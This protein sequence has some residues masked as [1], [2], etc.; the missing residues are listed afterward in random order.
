MTASASLSAQEKEIEDLT[1]DQR[2]I[3]V[4]QLTAKVTEQNLKDFFG[5]LG[6]VRNVIMIRDKATGRHKGFAYIEMGDLET[7]PNCLLFNNVV[8]D[9]QKFAILV[10]ASEA[11]KNFLAKKESASAAARATALPGDAMAM[12]N[13]LYVGNLHVNVVE[14]D[15][16]RLL[17]EIGP[18]ESVNIQ[19]DELGQSKGYAFVRM[20]RPQD[21]QTAMTRLAGVELAGRPIKVGGVTDANSG[22]PSAAMAAVNTQASA[23]W[24]LDDDEG[25]GMQMNAQSRAML[26][27]KLSGGTISMPAAAPARPAAAPAAPAPPST[28]KIS[29]TLSC[30]F[31]VQNMFDPSKE[32]EENWDLDVKED[33]CEE[34]RK[35]GEVLHCHVDKRNPTGLVYLK[36]G[37]NQV[38]ARAAE[39]LHGRWFAGRQIT[40]TYMPQ[41]HYDSMF[42]AQYR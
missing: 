1:K 13:R 25:M 31:V 4:S 33:V 23:N 34:C 21:A 10:K 15:L 16:H 8:P 28:P 39:N 12:D 20:L 32:T 29:G 5:Q 6:A 11:E 40:V 3:F 19:K 27:A 14:A 37:N 35:F 2:T 24:R 38:A 41:D 22:M 42:S 30:C 17:A 18:V 7:I 36:F 26:M 9:F